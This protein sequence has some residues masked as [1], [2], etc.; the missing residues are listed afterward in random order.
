M[1]LHTKVSLWK[2][3]LRIVAG[4]ALIHGSFFVAGSF[5]IFAEIFGVVE[6]IDS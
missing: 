2:S 5:I 4:G 6:E 1:R 3:V